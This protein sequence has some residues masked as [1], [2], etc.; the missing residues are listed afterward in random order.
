MFPASQREF[1]ITNFDARFTFEVD[2]QGRATAIGMHT[3]TDVRAA[4]AR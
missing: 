2:A 3:D 4:R 1:Y